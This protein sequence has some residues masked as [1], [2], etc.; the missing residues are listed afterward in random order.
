MSQFEMLP[1]EMWRR[2]DFAAGPMD[3]WEIANRDVIGIH[4]LMWGSDLPPR[5]RHLSHTREH[6]DKHFS[7]VGPGSVAAIRKKVPGTSPK[8]ACRRSISW[9]RREE[10]SARGAAG[11]ASYFIQLAGRRAGSHLVRAF[12]GVSFPRAGHAAR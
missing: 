7:E 10:P 5:G 4:N 6:L 11:R 3:P 1:S 12:F 9:R 8:A 2:Q